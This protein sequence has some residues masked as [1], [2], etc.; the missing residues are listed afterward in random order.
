MNVYGPNVKRVACLEVKDGV[1][2]DDSHLNPHIGDREQRPPRRRGQSSDE[3]DSDSDSDRGQQQVS[4]FFPKKTARVTRR[5]KSKENQL[6]TVLD[7]EGVDYD[8]IE[9]HY[10]DDGIQGT[11]HSDD[12]ATQ[13]DTD[14]TSI[15]EDGQELDDSQLHQQTIVISDDENEDA[16]PG[17][18]DGLDDHDF[19][20]PPSVQIGQSQRRKQKPEATQDD[21][22]SFLSRVK[23]LPQQEFGNTH[24]HNEE[25]VSFKDY[26]PTQNQNRGLTADEGKLSDEPGDFPSLPSAM[27]KSGLQERAAEIPL[28]ND[29]DSDD[30]SNA[31]KAPSRKKVRAARNLERHVRKHS[32][33]SSRAHSLWQTNATSV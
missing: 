5:G 23:P 6:Q 15:Y 28:Q 7:N 17:G 10:G 9:D 2:L 4:R 24:R 33:G 8:D 26:G 29:D 31:M 12:Y 27:L 16:A 18:L 19:E 3:R 25:D 13:S 1:G 32:N 22:P 21:F 30:G 14:E 20:L 11:A